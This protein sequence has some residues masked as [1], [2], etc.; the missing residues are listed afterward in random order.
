MPLLDL[1]H[2]TPDQ[3]AALLENPALEPPDGITSNFANPSN[4]NVLSITITVLEFSLSSIFV[5]IRLYV[6]WVVH[7]TLYVT[8]VCMIIA[9]GSSVAYYGT[10]ISTISQGG[11]LVHQWDITFRDYLHV[12]KNFYITPTLFGLFIMFIKFAIV[13]EWNRIFNPRRAKNVFYWASWIILAVNALFYI[14]SFFIVNLAC[15]P[16]ER[17]YNPFIEGTCFD[18]EKV[19]LASGVTNFVVDVAIL[20]LP[21]KLIWKLQMSRK[22]KNGILAVFGVGILSVVSAGARLAW[23]VRLTKYK[24]VLYNEAALGLWAS[25]EMTS[26]LI[27]FCVPSVPKFLQ[28]RIVTRLLSLLTRAGNDSHSP[29]SAGQLRHQEGIRQYYELMGSDAVLLEAIQSPPAPPSV[30]LTGPHLDTPRPPNLRILRTTEIITSQE[31]NENKS[32]TS[33]AAI[34][35]VRLLEGSTVF[36]ERFGQGFARTQ[37]DSTRVKHHQ[38]FHIRGSRNAPTSEP[39]VR[40]NSETSSFDTTDISRLYTRT[41]QAVTSPHIFELDRRPLHKQI[42]SLQKWSKTELIFPFQALFNCHVA[43]GQV[44]ACIL[45]KPFLLGFGSSWNRGAFE[46]AAACQQCAVYSELHSSGSN[47]FASNRTRLYLH[48]I[49]SSITS[50]VFQASG[51]DPAITWQALMTSVLGSAYYD[52]L[53]AFSKN[54]TATI[55]TVV[56]RSQPLYYRGYIIVMITVTLQLIIYVVILALFWK[57]TYFSLLGNAWL[58]VSQA[59]SADTMPL[60]LDSTMTLDKEVKAYV[61]DP[62]VGKIDLREEEDSAVILVRSDTGRVCV[63]R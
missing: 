16:W 11:Y 42:I 48:P 61:D 27:V 7:K 59:V 58:A 2:L 12:S 44:I 1:S 55:T 17:F 45:W 14:P 15:R 30:H 26:A 57:F 49:L 47:A 35:V 19:Y 3:Q 10:V 23:T 28:S 38:S 24:D 20:L 9:F 53:P 51:Y 52:W 33:S 39:T 21:Q 18:F 54:E 32:A 34:R 8:D 46:I 25:A 4:G 56:E 50:D 60:L 22:K 37:I 31:G 62:R 43:D 40:W 5:F 36:N 29:R 63:H 13:L 6:S 41:L